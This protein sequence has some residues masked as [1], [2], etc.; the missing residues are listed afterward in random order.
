MNIIWGNY[1]CDTIDNMKRHK[2][3]V[4]SKT[5]DHILILGA[6][7][8]LCELVGVIGSMLTIPQI[9]TWYPTLVK[10]FFSPPNWVFGPVW[11]LLYACMGFAAYRIWLQGMKKR[12]HRIAMGIFLVQL[13]VNFLW[14]FIFFDR[15]NIPG[16]FIDIAVMWLLI[17]Y[18]VVKLE[19]ID[20]LASYAMIPYLLWVSFAMVLNYYLWLLNV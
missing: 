9:S 19:H 16:G 2:P 17:L 7:I 15:H 13:G 11:T 12:E 1:C 18:L 6:W 10:P 14:S 3:H 8:V 5:G 20:R 4:R